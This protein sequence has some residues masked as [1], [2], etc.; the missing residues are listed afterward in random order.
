MK[1]NALTMAA[2]LA[3]SSIYAAQPFTIVGTGQTKCY[4]NAREIAPPRP[5]VLRTGR[6]TSRAK[7]YL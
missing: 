7:G 2:T 5:A 4:D 1:R 3:A 6:A